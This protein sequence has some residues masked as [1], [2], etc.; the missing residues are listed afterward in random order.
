MSTHAQTDS[1]TELLIKNRTALLLSG[2]LLGLALLY[3]LTKLPDSGLILVSIVALPGLILLAFSFRL[4]VAALV[5]SLFI[6][7][8]FIYLIKLSNI[9][10]I[11]VIFSYFLTHR[12]SLRGEIHFP[13]S[14]AFWLFF[15][16][17]LPSFINAAAPEMSLLM[18]SNLVIL[19]GLQYVIFRHAEDFVPFRRFFTVFFAINVVNSLYII[20]LVL[21]LGYGRTFGFSGIFFGDFAAIGIFS[22]LVFL[23][24]GERRNRTAIYGTAAML[25]VGLLL[26]QTRNQLLNL[27]LVIIIFLIYLITKGEVVKVKRKNLVLGVLTVVLLGVL[28]VGVLEVAGVNAF[29]RVESSTAVDQKELIEQGVTTNSLLTRFF[30]W[31]IG[32]KAFSAHPIVGIGMYGFP[33]ISEQYSDL[34]DIIYSRYVKTLTPHVG[35][36]GVLI[37]TGI[38]G[39]IAFLFYVFTLNRIAF[40]AIHFAKGK[41]EIMYAVLFAFIQVYISISLIF[42]DGWLWGMGPVLWGLTSGMMFANYRK[43]VTKY[44]PVSKVE[45]V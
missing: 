15:I 37:E 25:L 8:N 11:Q 3:V 21:G 39:L 27:I 32:W 14:D 5:L 20:Y 22:A 45:S 30:I 41:E 42:T 2:V 36:Y 43:V 7:Q 9:L 6:D 13:A 34:P 26:T 40:R 44:Q 38:V 28:M 31:Q 16:A 23:V 12:G 10:A 1:P 4:S 19:V 29:K 33:F 35:Y 17:T 18:M 24:Y